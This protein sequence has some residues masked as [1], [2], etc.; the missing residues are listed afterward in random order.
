[1][2]W[3]LGRGGSTILALTGVRGYCW[4]M[5][6]SRGSVRFD[7]YFKV[8]RW[9]PRSV[10]WIDI[11]RAHDTLEAAIAAAGPGERDRDWRIMLVTQDGRRPLPA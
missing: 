4:G 8:Q 3:G 7:D 5:K 1:M 6:R 11:Q 10:A 9:E 2:G